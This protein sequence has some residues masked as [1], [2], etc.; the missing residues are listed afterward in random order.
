M[1]CVRKLNLNIT[2]C[3]FWVTQPASYLLPVLLSWPLRFLPPIFSLSLSRNW[4]LRQNKKHDL[5]LLSE[6]RGNGV[7]RSNETREVANFHVVETN[8][9]KERKKE[10]VIPES[11]DHRPR[12]LRLYPNPMSHDTPTPFIT[13]VICVLLFPCHVAPYITRVTTTSHSLRLF[14]HHFSNNLKPDP[15]IPCMG[16]PTHNF[17]ISFSHGWN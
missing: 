10:T 17:S 12:R 4:K 14:S 2:W 15:Y 3:S 5:L 7:G 9:I 11:H 1:P 13:R 6:A 16:R 8:P